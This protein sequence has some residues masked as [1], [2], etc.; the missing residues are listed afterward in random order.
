[1]TAKK[2]TDN[3]TGAS[4]ERAGMA[5]ARTLTEALPY[6]KRYAGR[7]IAIKYGGHAM[8]DA[9]LRKSFAKDVVLIKQLGANPV[10]IHGGG[11]QIA[12]MLKRLAIKSSFVD[13]LRVTDADTVEVVEMVLPGSI[14]KAIVSEINQAG[15]RAVG[16]S[17]KDGTLIIAEKLRRTVR[18]PDSQIER[19]LDLG[20]V[21]EPKQVNPAVLETILASDLIPVIAP[22]G[23]G[24]AGETYN[25]N[26]DT[27]AGAI[28]AAL[29]AMRFILLTD[30]PG[31]LNKQ[32]ELITNLSRAEAESLIQDGTISGGM[33]PKVETCLKSLD[34]GVEAAVIVDGRVGHAL[35]LEIY[36]EHGVGTLI[37][38]QR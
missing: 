6:L 17:G 33:I 12:D 10:V 38:D 34:Q 27:A 18:D 1:M 20:F 23:V 32:G 2:A 8:G 14:N 30:M 7:T 29:N 35:L 25:I 22:I 36:T 37:S 19:H 11:P 4:E 9:A 5:T 28:A 16:L 3:K 21:G 24:E 13:G 26:A 31:V 15:G